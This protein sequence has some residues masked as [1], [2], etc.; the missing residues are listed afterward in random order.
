[1]IDLCWAENK[2]I[3]CSLLFIVSIENREKLSFDK[4][5]DIL[6]SNQQQEHKLW[7]KYLK[8]P[9][10]KWSNHFYSPGYMQ[11]LV[12]APWRLVKGFSFS[13]VH[14]MVIVIR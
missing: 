11:W 8:S 4:D 5:F 3:I 10:V 6:E 2:L 14:A 7:W 1:M 9:F 13:R 12:R